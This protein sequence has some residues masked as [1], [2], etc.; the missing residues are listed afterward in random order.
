MLVHTAI[1]GGLLTIKAFKLFLRGVRSGFK[2]GLATG[3][4]ATFHD[5]GLSRSQVEA[6]A[7]FRTE[8][9][10]FYFISLSK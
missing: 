3:L 6:F 2:A 10:L 7:A 5:V 1:P 4:Q 8:H 9:Y